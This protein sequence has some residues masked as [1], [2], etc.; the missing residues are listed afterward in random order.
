MGFR[1]GIFTFLVLFNALPIYAL[2][3]SVRHWAP[4]ERRRTMFLLAL[5]LSLLINV[6]I[7]I[8]WLRQFYNQLYDIPAGLLRSVFVP[9]VAWQTS[10]VLFTL[11]LG[12][13]Y[14]VWAGWWIVRGIRQKLRG[15]S[16]APPTEPGGAV[17][18]PPPAQS[19]AQARLISRRAL[20]AGGPGLIVPA[21]TLGLTGKMYLEDEVDISDEVTVPIPN[22][23]RQ[24]DGMTVVQLTDLHAGPYIRRREIEYW[25]SLANELKPDLV[26]LTGDLIDRSM[27]SLPDLLGG[28]GG[29]RTSL[30]SGVNGGPRLGVVAVLGNHDLSSDPSSSRGDLRGGENISRALREMGIRSL[31]N[32]VLHL[33][34]NGFTDA[35]QSAGDELAILGMDWVRRRDG[36][37]FFA[38]HSQE[39]R[40]RLAELTSRV[41]PGTAAMLLTHHPD[42]FS[43][44]REL[45]SRFSIGLTLAGHT[46]GGGQVVFFEWGGRTYGLTSVQFQYVSGLFQQN[47][48]SLYVNRGLGYFGV[49]IRIN[50][51]PEISRF[52]LVRQA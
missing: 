47:G 30:G 14:V 26:V 39:T 37:N 13:L 28:L 27:D 21:L 12:P 23:P 2:I 9:A 50:C 24:L 18:A 16:S 25:V 42:T 52:K 34:A 43:E 7:S 5:G 33:G 36:G 29:L 20:L 44:V 3:Q 31:R 38:Y 51:P 40:E 45:S 6:P 48:C 10:A 32:E 8:F 17:P 19:P 11:L 35:V 15:D 22:L 41:E 4:P 1:L 49:P 46:H